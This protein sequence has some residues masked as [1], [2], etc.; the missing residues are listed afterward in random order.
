MPLGR[1]GQIAG[2]SRNSVI[3]PELVRES[4]K[5]LGGIQVDQRGADQVILRLDQHASLVKP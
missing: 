2:N 5:H 1:R 3:A 4:R